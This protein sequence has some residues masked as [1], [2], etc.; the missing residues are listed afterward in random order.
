MIQAR[1]YPNLVR[2]PVLSRRMLAQHH[3]HYR[4]AVEEWN[5][6]QERWKRVSWEAAPAALG[7]IPGDVARLLDA[8]VADLGLAG[9]EPGGQ[10]AAAVEQVRGELNARG[11][12]WFPNLVAGEDE[13]F[14]YDRATTVSLPWYLFQDR[15]WWLVNDRH[16]RYPQDEVVRILRHEVGH[17][18]NYAFEAWKR[19]DWAV[20]FGEFDRP[21]LQAYPVDPT[22]TDFVRHLHRSGPHQNSHYAQKHPDEDWAETFATWLAPGEDWR[23][24]YQAGTGARRKLEWVDRAINE[25]GILRGDP[26]NRARGRVTDWRSL[27][28]TVREFMGLDVGTAWSDHAALARRE[29]AVLADVV[30]HELYFEQLGPALAGPPPGGLVAVAVA[31][32]GSYESWMAD[33]RA[34]CTEGAG[35]AVASWDPRLGRLRNALVGAGGEGAPV[36]AAPLLVLDLAEH[37]YAAD[38][39][40]RV[41]LY[42]AGVLLHLD[43]SV[44]ER[45]GWEAGA[46]QLAVPA[47]A[48]G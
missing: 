46:W 30:L 7:L 40:N 10:L 29:P 47:L 28:Y 37:A 27:P 8:R 31:A 24:D 21:Y 25:A 23:A 18:L 4:R 48:V 14:T 6:I 44:V 19:A 42:A 22:S 36:G 34:L 20:L 41:D 12:T 39:G 2:S 45:R 13:F 32:F 38:Y 33:L 3:Q 11:I 16:Y 43:W 9:P 35:W 5:A 17:A 15:L 1:E 26:P